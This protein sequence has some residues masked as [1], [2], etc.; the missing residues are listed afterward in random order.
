MRTI[1]ES[2]TRD[3]AGVPADVV[4]APPVRALLESAID[5]AGLFPPA[6]LSMPEAVS[7]FATYRSSPEAWALGRFILPVSRL[8]EFA[9]N[10]SAIHGDINPDPRSA[11]FQSADLSRPG[12]GERDCRRAAGARPAG[13]NEWARVSQSPIFNRQGSRTSLGAPV[14]A[15]RRTGTKTPFSASGKRRLRPTRR[16]AKLPRS[17]PG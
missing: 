4:P 3:I 2:L 10:L 15:G 16:S 6:S 7:N 17:L 12:D 9:A 13:L 5:Y 1:P 8:S 14:G 11:D